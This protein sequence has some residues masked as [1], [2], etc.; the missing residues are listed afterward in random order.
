MKRRWWA[1]LVHGIAANYH[2]GEAEI[3][4]LPLVRL[5]AYQDELLKDQGSPPLEDSPAFPEQE[6]VRR[7]AMELMR[8]NG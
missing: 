4:A 2:W 6:E 3:L 5:N 1:R 8:Q 7:L